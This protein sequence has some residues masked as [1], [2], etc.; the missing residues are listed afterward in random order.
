MWLVPQTSNQPGGFE[1]NVCSTV[2][3]TSHNWSALSTVEIRFR[4]SYAD[5]S[6]ISMSAHLRHNSSHE[7]RL[8][9]N[10][11]SV[12]QSRLFEVFLIRAVEA[13][14]KRRTLWVKFWVSASSLLYTSS[15]LGR[16]T[17]CSH[18][19]NSLWIWLRTDSAVSRSGATSLKIPLVRSAHT[20]SNLPPARNAMPIW[21]YH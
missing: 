14:I 6:I 5:R 15:Y 3:G 7:E 1:R 17:S 12:L 18:H 2:T 4:N 21:N 8:S 11:T 10:L 13:D 19:Y 20:L 16:A 9:C